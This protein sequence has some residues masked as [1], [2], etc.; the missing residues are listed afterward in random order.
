MST[1]PDS[2]LYSALADGEV[3]SPWKEKLE[4]HA[5]SC[6]AC[7]KL[8]ARYRKLDSL[9]T[10]GGPAL[11]EERLEASYLKLMARR[12]A[13]LD[14]R[15]AA[16]ADER[17]AHAHALRFPAWAHASISLPLP[18][19]AALFAFAVF[20]PSLIALRS[21]GDRGQK[22]EYA[23]I[24]PAVRQAG[25][26]GIRAISTSSSVYSPDLPPEMLATN[27]LD[28][29]SKQYFTMIDFAKQ[30]ANDDSLFSD[31]GSIVIIKLPSL[32]RFDS[33]SFAQDRLLEIEE[34]LKQAAGF[35]R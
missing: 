22:T 21:G 35:Y 19:L 2:N 14:A 33:H 26:G 9:I 34:P 31:S 30:F 1:C 16:T 13:S 3:P 12:E 8:V 6:A 17:P 28:T 20:V 18:A 27:V 10:E 15:R 5:R 25:E 4:E 23:S 11:T 24:I 29:K 7:Q 32:A